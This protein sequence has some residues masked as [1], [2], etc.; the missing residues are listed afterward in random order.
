MD[1]IKRGMTNFFLSLAAGVIIG[2]LAGA[3]GFNALVSYKVD[4]YHQRI[5]HLE[6]VVED[7]EARL[8][9]LEESIK[10]FSK[11]KGSYMLTNIEVILIYEGDD[12][13]KTTLEKNIKAKLDHLLGREVKSIDIE[14]VEQVI[15]NRIFKSD[16]KEFKLKVDKILLDEV[17]KIWVNVDINAK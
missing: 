17:L 1:K 6:A 11:S 3:A 5:K 16:G 14:T 7:K 9:K 4:E 8:K 12:L 15:D 13:E 2:A 10:E